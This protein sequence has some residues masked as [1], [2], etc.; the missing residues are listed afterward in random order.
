MTGVKAVRE[1]ILKSTLSLLKIVTAILL[2]SEAVACDR[3]GISS[4]LSNK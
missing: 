4:L 2:I 3:S 1:I